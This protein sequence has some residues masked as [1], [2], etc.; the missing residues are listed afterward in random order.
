MCCRRWM[1][2]YL[3]LSVVFAKWWQKASIFCDFKKPCQCSHRFHYELHPHSDVI[4]TFW[5]AGGFEVC[6]SRSWHALKWKELIDVFSASTQNSSCLNVNLPNP[7]NKCQTSIEQHKMKPPSFVTQTKQ[8]I[9]NCLDGRRK[10]RA[11]RWCH[12]FGCAATGCCS[13]EVFQ[14]SHCLGIHFIE[15]PSAV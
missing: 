10:A 5:V 11:F 13:R 4:R 6:L 2:V 8:T 12:R 3:E 1:S 15:G 7:P 14:N 9:G